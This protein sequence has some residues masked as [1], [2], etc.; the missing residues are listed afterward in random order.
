M[1]TITK[2]L[3]AISALKSLNPSEPINYRRQFRGLSNINGG[4]VR[5]RPSSAS[6][7]SSGVG[8]ITISTPSLRESSMVCK[9]CEH[10]GTRNEGS[11]PAGYFMYSGQQATL[12]SCMATIEE[13][14]T[15]RGLACILAW[16]CV[17]NSVIAACA[18]DSITDKHY[19]CGGSA[20]G[21]CRI[22]S[23]ECLGADGG[24]SSTQQR[25]TA[26]D[27][28]WCCL[29]DTE[30]CTSRIGKWRLLQLC[31]TGSN[32]LCE[33]ANQRMHCNTAGYD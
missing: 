11:F 23:P 14:G 17:Q 13:L 12:L 9:A 21:T 27:S 25:C 30:S 22:S 32:G 29:K 31:A 5:C 20:Q 10:Y 24:P 19:C 18:Y 15:K 28:D 1:I 26:G 7:A 16:P 4:V 2:R 6:S 33:R 8:L 3:D